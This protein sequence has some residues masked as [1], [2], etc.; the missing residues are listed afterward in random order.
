MKFVMTVRKVGDEEWKAWKE[1]EE[2]DGVATLAEAEK[3]SR[4]TIERFN[5]TL[6]PGESPR[7]LLS[8][9]VDE[10]SSGNVKKHDWEKTNLVTIAPRGDG[11]FY[12]T[13][14]CNRCG[15]TAKRYGIGGDLVLDSKFKKA[16]VYQRCDTSLAHRKKRGEL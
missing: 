16:K 12:D 15:I 5:N 2:R 7:E 13:Y 1:P 6:R 11:A 10:S 3:W 9:T 8:V 4:D 14:G